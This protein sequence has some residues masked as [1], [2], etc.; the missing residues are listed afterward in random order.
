M[1]YGNKERFGEGRVGG[2]GENR[3]KKGREGDRHEERERARDKEKGWRE[4]SRH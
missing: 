1:S 2:K 3:E 4:E